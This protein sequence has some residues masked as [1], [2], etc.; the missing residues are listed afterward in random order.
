MSTCP[1][2]AS[3]SP[4][5]GFAYGGGSLMKILFLLFCL[6]SGLVQGSSAHTEHSKWHDLDCCRRCWRERLWFAGSWYGPTILGAST[7]A[8]RTIISLLISFPGSTSLRQANLDSDIDHEERSIEH[9]SGH[10]VW[11]TV[12]L[13]RYVRDWTTRESWHGVVKRGSFNTH[14]NLSPQV[15]FAWGTTR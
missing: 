1:N 13:V 6:L 7:T 9:E 2:G 8:N 10:P 14:R 3:M 4:S 11:S 15:T 12:L 5:C